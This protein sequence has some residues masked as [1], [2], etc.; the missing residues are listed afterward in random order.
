MSVPQHKR[1]AKA[2]GQY[3]V[4]VDDALSDLRRPF[5]LDGVVIVIIPA[6]L[7][8]IAFIF[9][10]VA[11]FLTTLGLGG[12]NAE[13][14]LRRG[15]TVLKSYWSERSKLKKTVQRLELELLLCS[16]SNGAGLKDIEKLLRAYVNALLP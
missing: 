5:I 9:S 2:I 4:V 10:N 12:I 11:G 16:P 8:V 14:R 1:L 13:E 3:E 7:S 15:Q 6:V